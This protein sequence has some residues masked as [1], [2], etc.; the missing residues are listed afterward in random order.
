MI[1]DANQDAEVHQTG[2]GLGFVVGAPVRCIRAPYFGQIG[3]VHSLPVELEVMPSETKVR[4]VEVELAGGENI[5]L[6]RANVE[7]IEG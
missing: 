4:V 7:V 1:P 6:P 5:R 2:T 3:K